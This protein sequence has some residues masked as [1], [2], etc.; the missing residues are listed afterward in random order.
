MEAKPVREGSEADLNSEKYEVRQWDLERKDSLRPLIATVNKI[1]RENEALQSDWT[2]EFH[3]VD[4]ERLI[5]YSKRSL[6]GLN[7]I[8][9]VVNLDPHATQ[10]G[11][12]TLPLEVLG[13]AADR[14][15]DIEDL[16]TGATYEWNGARNFVSLNPEN[17]PG[18]I[19]RVVR[20]KEGD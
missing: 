6:D 3:P 18:H 8:V 4:N 2:V 11:F 19:L 14:P 13:I 15:Y 7:V 5:C 10:W 17:L 12:V 1:R 20:D 16:L 9:V